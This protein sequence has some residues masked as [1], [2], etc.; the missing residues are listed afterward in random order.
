V[1]AIWNGLDFLADP[2]RVG[3]FMR[4]DLVRRK[5]RACIQPPNFECLP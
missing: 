2:N 3:I 1:L 4:A 5:R